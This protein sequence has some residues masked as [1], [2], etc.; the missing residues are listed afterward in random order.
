MK[1]CPHAAKTWTSSK[2]KPNAPAA[3]TLLSHHPWLWKQ[4][5]SLFPLRRR[6]LKLP[7]YTNG[8]WT[9]RQKSRA[10]NLRSF[11]VT[12]AVVS[13]SG[14]LGMQR[15]TAELRIIVAKN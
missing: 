7:G 4:K 14:S 2:Q 15:N 3:S 13:S 12:A 1:H 5:R 8:Y 6:V 10:S 9:P 11:T